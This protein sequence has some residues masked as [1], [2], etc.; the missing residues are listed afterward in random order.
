MAS[1]NFHIQ[2]EIYVTNVVVAI[3]INRKTRKL[4]SC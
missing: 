3:D 2:F 4:V 1:M